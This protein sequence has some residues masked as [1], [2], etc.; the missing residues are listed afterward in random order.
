MFIALKL[1]FM[2]STLT[3]GGLR[4][5]SVV[6]NPEGRETCQKI[7]DKKGNSRSSYVGQSR[8]MLP[9]FQGA[10]IKIW[11]LARSV[12]TILESDRTRT[13]GRNLQVTRQCG[14][15]FKS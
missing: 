12:N 14:L 13:D 9:A 7:N 1:T 8:A 5:V 10:K 2:T 6:G 3:T 4:D 15:V 11:S